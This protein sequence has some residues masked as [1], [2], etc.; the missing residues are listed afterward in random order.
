MGSLASRPVADRVITFRSPS[1]FQY[2]HISF[3]MRPLAQR[4]VTRLS[5]SGT[6]T[7]SYNPTYQLMMNV[8]LDIAGPRDANIGPLFRHNPS[9]GGFTGPA[10][11]LDIDNYNM[12]RGWTNPLFRPN[13]SGQNEATPRLWSNPMLNPPMPVGNHTS[14]SRML[15]HDVQHWD[16]SAGYGSM[17][18]GS[19][20]WSGTKETLT[21]G[22]FAKLEILALDVPAHSSSSCQFEIR[23]QE[24]E[25]WN[26]AGIAV[27]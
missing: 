12:S 9:M 11:Q 19:E 21:D 4:P 18:E 24:Q 15:P 17:V 2:F 22:G 6:P 23:I 27:I 8:P 25:G 7:P 26:W 20:G 14:G 10:S 5:P 16:W 3:Q 13:I 1:S